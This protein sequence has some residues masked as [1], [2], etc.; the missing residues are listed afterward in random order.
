MNEER[1]MVMMSSA[2]FE[3]P[4]LVNVRLEIG[5]GLQVRCTSRIRVS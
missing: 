3:A 2:S 5:S 4:L 1:C